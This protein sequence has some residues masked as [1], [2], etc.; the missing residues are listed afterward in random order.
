MT[1]GYAIVLTRYG[2]R[3]Y[4]LGPKRFR[5]RAKVRDH[6]GLVQEVER[7]GPSAS[8]AENLLK[9]ARSGTLIPRWRDHRGI[10]RARAR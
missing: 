6:D 1:N 9:E 8:T 5:A 10:H 4:R 2:A 7:T 3:I